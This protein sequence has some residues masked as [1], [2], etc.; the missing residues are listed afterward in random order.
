[1]LDLDS[2]RWG[3]LSH[4]YGNALDVP[5]L[6][7]QLEANPDAQGFGDNHAREWNR[8]QYEMYHTSGLEPWTSLWALLCHQYTVY[9]ASYAALPHIVRIAS[10]ATNPPALDFLFLPVEIAYWRTAPIV[11]VVPPAI[12]IDLVEA[13]ITALRH[14]PSL[15]PRLAVAEWDET[16]ARYIAGAL[17]TL[18]GHREVAEGIEAMDRSDFR[19]YREFKSEVKHLADLKAWREIK[20]SEGERSRE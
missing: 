6:L 5:A 2:P 15:I 17:L 11:P 13:Y 3:E 14:L 18:K 20:T 9:T 8:W 12:P 19:A 10:L 7:R 16:S 1:M 4:A